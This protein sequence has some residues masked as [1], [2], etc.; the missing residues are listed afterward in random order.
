MKTT[1]ELRDGRLLDGDLGYGG[2]STYL[3]CCRGGN[4]TFNIVALQY[5]ARNHR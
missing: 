1:R 2:V 5:R 4:A 3:K